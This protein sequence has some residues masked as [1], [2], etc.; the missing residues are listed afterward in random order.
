MREGYLNTLFSGYVDVTKGT[1]KSAQQ[2]PDGEAFLR[3]TP[4]PAPVVYHLLPSH[5]RLPEALHIIVCMYGWDHS[6]WLF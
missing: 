1:K 2:S 6:A 4:C 3:L 5:P